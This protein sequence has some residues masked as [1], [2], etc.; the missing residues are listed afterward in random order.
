M[1]API[2]A[3]QTLAD[4]STYKRLRTYRGGRQFMAD[5]S[6]TIDLVSTTPKHTWEMSWPALT[7]TQMTALQTVFDALKDVSGSY[8]DIDGTV[9]TVT[10]GEGYDELERTFVRAQ[11]GTRWAAALKLRQV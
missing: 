2:L 9:Y 1:A 6:M 7:D 10:L 5:G 8:T 4:P 3:G 11:A